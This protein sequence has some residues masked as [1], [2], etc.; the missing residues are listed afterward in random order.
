MGD[1]TKNGLYPL[2]AQCCFHLKNY[3]NQITVQ[4]GILMLGCVGFSKLLKSGIL[5][6]IIL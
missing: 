3:E 6:F 1:L 2:L 4:T 5:Y